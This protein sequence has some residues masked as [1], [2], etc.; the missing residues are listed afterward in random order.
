MTNFAELRARLAKN[1]TLLSHDRAA[2]LAL[3]DARI[4]AEVLC[5]D[6]GCPHHGTAHACVTRRPVAEFECENC[7]GMPEAGCYCQAVGAIAPGWSACRADCQH[8]GYCHAFDKCQLT[9]K[10]LDRVQP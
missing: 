6:E 9:Q 7:I 4:A 1:I 5:V 3:V 8:T 2:L 10:P